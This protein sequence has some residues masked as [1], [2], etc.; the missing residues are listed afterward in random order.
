VTYTAN[1]SDPDG[2]ASIEL[3]EDRNTLAACSN[4]MHCATRVSTTRLTTCSFSPALSPAT[5]SFTTPAPYPDASFIGYRAVARDSKGNSAAE[6]WIY[7]AAGASPWPND[8]IPIYAKGAPAEKVDLVFIPDP[9]YNGNNNQFMQNVTALLTNGYLSTGTF[10]TDIRTWRGFWN[11]Y[12]TYQTGDAQG[13]GNGCNSAPANWANL[14]A[15]V[16]SGGILHNNALRDCGGVGNGS[17]F[18]VQVGLAVTNPTVVHETG[19]SVFSMADEYCCDGGYWNIGPE[20]NLFN[21]QAS[22]Q[23]NATSH[24]WATTDCVQIGTTGWWRSDGANDLMQNNNSNANLYGRSDHKRVMWLYF[25]ECSGSP[26][27]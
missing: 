26:G 4:G 9:D 12:I 19:H 14:S 25:T 16:N 11:F 7:Y 27:C 22:C 5:C 2:V 6:G 15:I 21:S 13:Y 3:W 17:L 8:P 10:A 1:A 23:T 18:S 20:A 24:G